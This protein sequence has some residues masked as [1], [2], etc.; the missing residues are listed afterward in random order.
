M[1]NALT[2]MLQKI[3]LMQVCFGLEK[4][5]KH[6][7]ILQAILEEIRKKYFEYIIKIHLTCIF[8]AAIQY[9][10]CLSYTVIYCG[11]WASPHSE[12]NLVHVHTGLVFVTLHY[13]TP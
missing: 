13:A 11:T 1:G 2:G 3:V 10:A 4:F 7:F 8:N 5:G 6:Q 12:E 9:V